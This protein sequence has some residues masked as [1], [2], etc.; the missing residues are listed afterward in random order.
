MKPAPAVLSAAI[1]ALFALPASAELTSLSLAELDSIT[2]GTEGLTPAPNGGAIVGNGSTAVLQ[3]TGEVVLSDAAQSGATALNLVNS[4]ESTVANGV[5]IF[6]GRTDTAA[7]ID[8]A[9]FEISQSNFVVQDQRR[10]SSLPTYERGANTDTLTTTSGTSSS[11]STT[12]LVD[13]VIDLERSTWIDEVTTDGSFD[14]SSAPTLRIE[15]EGDVEIGDVID[16]D[17]SYSAEFNMPSASNSLG[18]TFNGEFTYGINGGEIEVDTGDL[19]ILVT[20]NLPELDLNFDA[21]GCFAVNGNCTIDGTRVESTDEISDHSTLYTY[22]ETSTSSETWDNSTHEIVA[23]PFELHNAQAEYIVIDESQI[24]VSAAYLV[25][26]SGEAQSALRG[27][28]A[29]NAAGSAVANGV[30][31]ALQRAGEAEIGGGPT[32]SLSQVNHINHSR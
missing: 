10:L 22:D 21:M 30:N 24:D 27:L 26:L 2:A 11:D 23:A 18:A 25:G 4:S 3:S 13:S 20:V 16:V 32:Y 7:S 14:R 28:N 6:D 29:V 17:G 31:I 19:G 12:S 1:S 9:Q 5:N 8:G 15:V